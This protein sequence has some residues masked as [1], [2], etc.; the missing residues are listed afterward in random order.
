MKLPQNVGRIV[1]ENGGAQ[2]PMPA[3]QMGGEMP[4]VEAMPGGASAMSKEQMVADLESKAAE[5]NSKNSNLKA[6]EISDSNITDEAR[7]SL[8]RDLFDIMK[9]AGVDPANPESVRAFL[10]KLSETD[11]DLFEVFEIAF[12][13]LTGFVPPEGEAPAATGAQL[14]PPGP[15]LGGAPATMGMVPPV[16]PPSGG[17]TAPG[18]M[19]KFNNLASEVMRPPQQ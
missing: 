15:E 4:P 11:P 6:K 1:S 2:P 14:P 10:E 9:K 7:S 17:G 18:L 8:L 3:A 16:A 12:N 19:G 5:L 13:N